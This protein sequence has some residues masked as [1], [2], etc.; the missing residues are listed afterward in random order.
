MNAPADGL[1]VRQSQATED[2][3]DML[4]NRPLCQSEVACNGRIAVARRNAAKHFML[5]WRQIVKG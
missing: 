2:L 4:F 1:V 3:A 5:P